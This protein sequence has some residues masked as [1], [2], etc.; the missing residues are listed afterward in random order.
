MFWPLSLP[1]ILFSQDIV[2]IL[3]ISCQLFESTFF[4]TAS[5]LTQSS[6]I[7]TMPPPVR[8]TLTV[9]LTLHPTGIPYVFP[10]STKL[11]LVK[12]VHRPHKGM[13]QTSQGKGLQDWRGLQAVREQSFLSFHSWNTKW[14]ADAIPEVCSVMN[15]DVQTVKYTE[16]IFP[17]QPLVCWPTVPKC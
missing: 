15:C 12:M 2:M 14:Q 6:A 16:C 1:L 13:T 9:L 8:V 4:T 11:T 7:T 10:L 5:L 3:Y 17:A